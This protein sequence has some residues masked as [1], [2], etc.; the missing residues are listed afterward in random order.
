MRKSFRFPKPRNP[1]LAVGAV[2]RIGAEPSASE[3]FVGEIKGW[4]ASDIEE[5]TARSLD[6]YGWSYEFRNVYNGRRNQSGSVELDFYAEKAGQIQP[7][8]TD[9]G[10]AHASSAQ[11]EEDAMKDAILNNELGRYGA[12]PVIRV[13]GYELENQ[14]MADAF[15]R[16]IL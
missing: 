10:Y 1:S 13:P 7:I 16:R 6:K 2:N 4:P 8:Q 15:Y 5:R 9:G 12:K 14:A 11:K 3:T